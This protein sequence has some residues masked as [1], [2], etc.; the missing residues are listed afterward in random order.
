MTP[1]PEPQRWLRFGALAL[2]AACGGGG[3]GGGAA[4]S[5]SLPPALGTAFTA[6]APSLMAVNCTGGPTTPAG[7]AFIDAEVEPFVAVN[8]QDGDHLVGAWQ[9]DRW[10]DGGARGVTTGVSF[11]GGR[12]WARSLQ[13]F[14]R[15]AGGTGVTGDYE[16]ATDPWVDIAPDGTVHAMGLAFNGGVLAAGSASAMLAARSTDG[17]R[18]WSRP[19]VL[20]R[21]GDTLFNDKN[22]LTADRTDARFVYAVWDRLDAAGRGPT[23]LARSTDGGLSWEP[24]REMF[25]PTSAGVSQTLG[26]RIVVLANGTLVNVFTQ[27]DT[28]GGASSAWLAVVRSTDK[29]V[30]WGAPVRIAD[31]RGI[32]ARDAQSGQA[33]RDGA[34]IPTIAVAA[35]GAIWVAWQDARFSAGARDAIA[36]SRS[37]DGGST[38]SAPVAVN[39]NLGVAAFTPTLAVRADGTVALLHYDL[40]TDD[41]ATAT[42]AS[43]WL[44]TTRDNGATWNEF[45]VLAPF[46]MANAPNARGLFL[47]DYQGLVSANGTFVPL[48]GIATGATTNRTEIVAVRMPANLASSLASAGERRAFAL[49]TPLGE[50]ADAQLR[51]ATHASIVRA[52]ERRLPGWAARVGATPP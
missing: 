8:P 25:V 11:D 29:G 16:R 43:T 30:T 24:A 32:G 36:V 5:P 23:L 50:A 51:A 20:V 7:T 9:Q 47:G 6:S 13:P 15:C 2:L 28:V 44:L 42:P 14:S 18:T 38:W 33:I 48:I 4:P 27:I 22:S 39:K 19:A 12:T 46:D 17:G 10:S 3:G 45:A 52:M 41:S 40:R 26:N 37:T 49:R 34:L 35:D 31:A 21:D 1:L